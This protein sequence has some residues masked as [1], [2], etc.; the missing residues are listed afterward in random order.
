LPA[1][2]SGIPFQRCQADGSSRGASA[3]CEFLNRF[4]GQRL[5]ADAPLAAGYF[6]DLHPGH[7]RMFSPSIETMASVNF[8]MICRFCSGLNTFSIRWTSINGIVLLLFADLARARSLAKGM[9]IAAN[10]D[11]QKAMV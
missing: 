9:H 7:P 3:S 6:G 8:W 11:F 5:A 1:S 4:G 2:L 10:P